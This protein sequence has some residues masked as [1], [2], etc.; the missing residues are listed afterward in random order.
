MTLEAYGGRHAG[1]LYLYGSN[2]ASGLYDEALPKAA[3]EAFESLDDRQ[4][5]CEPLLRSATVKFARA[6]FCPND[7]TGDAARYARTA[8]EEAIQ[9]GAKVRYGCIP[10]SGMPSRPDGSGKGP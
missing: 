8:L 9:L 10:R 2:D 6:V 4:L 3:G 7:G 1:I 5:D